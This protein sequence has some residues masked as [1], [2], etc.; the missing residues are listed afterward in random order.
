MAVAVDGQF[1]ATLP[2]MESVNKED[3]ELVWLVY[4]LTHDPIENRKRLTLTRSVYTRFLPALDKITK[5]EPGDMGEFIYLLQ[6]KLDEALAT[7]SGTGL[8]PDTRSLQSEDIEDI[9]E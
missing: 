1:F 7:G 8:T 4:D 9:V 5:S 3:A 2:P 6:A